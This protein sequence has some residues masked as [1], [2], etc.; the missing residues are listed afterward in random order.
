MINDDASSLVVE[1]AK[2][3]ITLMMGVEPQWE[4]A[5]LR[6]SCNN[7]VTELKASFVSETGVE[8]IDVL[9]Y[10]DFFHPMNM[11]GQELLAAL[12]KIKGVFLLV[13]DANFDY[14]INFEYQDM[15]RWKISKLAGGTG[16]PEG[17][18]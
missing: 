2:K 8:I 11:Q 6:F 15:N 12:G 18:I 4:K 17:I 5:Y 9:K 14:E 10:K 7:S 13:I 1:I 3:F 16:V